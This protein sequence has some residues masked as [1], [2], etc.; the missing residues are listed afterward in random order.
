MKSTTD[1]IALQL[2]SDKLQ[3]VEAGDGAV[4]VE[5]L[6]GAGDGRL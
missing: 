1:T 3:R 5:N 4:D 2:S 6:D